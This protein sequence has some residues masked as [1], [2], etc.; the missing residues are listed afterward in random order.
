MQVLQGLFLW[1][2]VACSASASHPL[3][4]WRGRNPFPT[5]DDLNGVA[6]G[7]GRF[8]AVGNT[9]EVVISGNGVDWFPWPVRLYAAYTI[10]FGE[11][12]FVVGGAGTIHVSRTGTDW[13]TSALP[14]EFAQYEAVRAV[15]FARTTGDSNVFFAISHGMDQSRGYRSADGTNWSPTLNRF[16]PGITSPYTSI[17]GGNNRIVAGGNEVS[18]WYPAP[19]IAYYIPQARSWNGTS[20]AR[21][22][23]A[24]GDG[25]FVIAEMFDTNQSPVALRAQVATNHES[26]VA[27]ELPV[28]EQPVGICYGGGR[29][30][31]VGG[32]HIATSPDGTNWV[33]TTLDIE[34]GLKAVTYGEGLYVAVGTGGLIVSSAD[35]ITWTVRTGGR[36]SLNSVTPDDDGCVAVGARGTIL[37][38]TNGAR[39]QHAP[40]GTSNSLLCVLK[41]AGKYVVAGERGALYAGNA[42]TSLVAR[43]SGTEWALNGMAHGNGTWVVVGDAGTI[44]TSADGELWSV[45]QTGI[46]NRLLNAAYGSGRFVAVG[47]AGAI[48]ASVDGSTWEVQAAPT[49]RVIA[50]VAYGN[51]M[52]LAVTVSGPALASTDGITWEIRSATRPPYIYEPYKPPWYPR[53]KSLTYGDGLFV[54][55]ADMNNEYDGLHFTSV[56]GRTWTSHRST[57]PRT[58]VV[59]DIAYNNG[60]VV[61]VGNHGRVFQ[62]AA[63]MQ[64]ELSGDSEAAQLRVSGPKESTYFIQSATSLAGP[65]ESMATGNSLPAE[66]EV[67][68]GATNRF[69]RAQLHGLY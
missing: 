37:Y 23:V 53:W 2:L 31:A 22:V 50:D 55:S 51:D 56:D 45:R 58:N 19:S 24:F 49:N 7:N 57:M 13:S 4:V 34:P 5:T 28:G 14:S 69:Y 47:D 32:T 33:T 39:W 8:V 38:S 59:N 9:G 6:Y 3:E 25:R 42:I 30:V 66:V 11:E 52:F 68:A 15:G 36:R 60:R 26:F 46:T 48:L 64:L 62:S 61:T 44:I 18:S 54:A 27:R 65:W 63:I 20:S 12:Q 21:G 10:T 67:P 43:D 17:A 41:A 16:W 1:L 29:F 40:L 35:G